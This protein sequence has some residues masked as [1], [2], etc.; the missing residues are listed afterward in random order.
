MS[1]MQRKHP[2][3]GPVH[4]DVS[5]AMLAFWNT[6]AKCSLCQHFLQSQKCHWLI[7][8]AFCPSL[9]QF[10]VVLNKCCRAKNALWDNGR[11]SIQNK[12]GEICS[13][14][15]RSEEESAEGQ[16]GG[17]GN[18]CLPLSCFRWSTPGPTGLSI[19]KAHWGKWCCLLQREATKCPQV[20]ATGHPDFLFCS[21]AFPLHS[22]LQLGS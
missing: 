22:P 1:R 6:I 11:A 7:L 4:C 2:L 9:Y 21:E 13:K 8:L 3:P 10:T 14:C 17:G 5:N 18:T 20:L 16:S 12:H 15:H 19:N